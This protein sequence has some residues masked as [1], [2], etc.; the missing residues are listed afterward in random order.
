[1]FENKWG[2]PQC[3]GAIDGSHITVVAPTECHTDFF[4]KKGWHSIILQGMVGPTYKF[5]DINVGWPGSV[6]DA[7]VFSRSSIYK[8]ASEGSLFPRI[9]RLVNGVD[10]PVLLIVTVFAKID[11][12]AQLLKCTY[13]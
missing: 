7:R 1:M 4:K 3:A 11:H 9:T 12:T 6:H 10:I 13:S 2:L 8:R 5:W